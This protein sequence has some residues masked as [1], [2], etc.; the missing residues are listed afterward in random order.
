[1]IKINM[2]Y[3]IS[4]LTNEKCVISIHEYSF[5][6]HFQSTI[7]SACLQPNEFMVLKSGL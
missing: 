2:S 4:P 3:E 7:F 1:M 5:Q 6:T